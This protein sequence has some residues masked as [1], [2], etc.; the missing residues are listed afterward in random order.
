MNI[1]SLR[2]LLLLNI[3]YI[4]PFYLYFNFV[5]LV[6]IIFSICIISIGYVIMSFIL[7]LKLFFCSF[8]LFFFFGQS[9]WGTNY[10]IC[11]NNQRFY[12]LPFSIAC[13]PLFYSLLL[14]CSYYHYFL[15]SVFWEFAILSYRFLKWVIII[16]NFQHFCIL[17]YEFISKHVTLS[18]P[19]ILISSIL[20]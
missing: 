15:I 17:I 20:M 19:H 14:F 2:F 8:S 5:D 7:F 9:W 11:F 6:F 4:F 3:F 13:L 12:F 16:V 1:R 18:A 10:L